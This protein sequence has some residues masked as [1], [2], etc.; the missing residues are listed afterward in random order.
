[1]TVALI[2]GEGEL[3]EEIAR[4]MA[5]KGERPIIY[6]MREDIDSLFPHAD[7]II[8]VFRTDLASTLM[9]MTARNVRQIMFAG[10]VPKTLLF[11]PEMMDD[12]A[13][14]LI[15][16]LE[17]RDDHALLGGIVAF[18]EKSGFEVI[19]YTDILRD[20]LAVPGRIAGR[21]PS[22]EEM[23]DVEYGIDIAKV[24]VP[25]SFGQ[26]IV[27]NDK[28]VVAVEAMEGTDAAVLRAG[29]LCRKGVL[30]KMMRKG[31]DSRFD[32]P[33]VGPRTLNLMRRAGLTCLAIQAGW[34]LVLSPEKFAAEAKEHDLSVVGIDY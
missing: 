4:R 9:D 5:L 27:V 2:A 7:D 28:S 18:F 17:T 23:T 20:L 8:P 30:I 29:S 13:R 19:G 33:V 22:C 1:M 3:P 6:T 25:L 34:T 24:V 14:Q 12:M 21:E 32:I 26:S 10:L 11:R 31:Q 15:A 16:S